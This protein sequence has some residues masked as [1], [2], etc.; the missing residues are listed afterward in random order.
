MGLL[1]P[2]LERQLR[3]AVRARSPA[4]TPRRVWRSYRPRL[5]FVTAGAL[6]A[7][8]VAVALGLSGES[9]SSAAAAALERLAQASQR[10]L[11][12]SRL[13]GGQYWYVRSIQADTIGGPLFLRR[14]GQGPQ[15][16][17]AGLVQR[18]QLV[19][20]W[21][22]PSAVRLRDVP[23][24]GSVFLG[25]AR[26]TALWRANGSPQE[27][28]AA[29][30]QTEVGTTGFNSP[31]GTLTYAQV[32]ALPTNP[33]AML[34]RI[35]AAA[36]AF[37]DQQRRSGRA[38][39]AAEPLPWLE[40]QFAGEILQNLPLASGARAAVYRALELVSGVRYLPHMRDPLGRPGVGLLTRG[41]ARFREASSA[42]AGTNA[43]SAELIFDPVTGAVLAQER[44]L[45][46]PLPPVGLSSGY[47]MSYT[48]YVLSGTVD[49]IHERFAAG[50]E[51]G[52][53]APAPAASPT[54]SGLTPPLTQIINAP[55]PP[56]LGSR[57]AVLRR[58][59]GIQ[60]APP[61]GIRSGLAPEL[62]TAIA[63]SLRQLR[64]TQSGTHDYLVVG[65][66]TAPPVPPRTCFPT[67]SRSKYLQ[68][69]D[70]RNT[71][72]KATSEPIL[73][74]FEVY[75]PLN[76]PCV[77]VAGLESIAFETGY[78]SEAVH[79]PPATVTGIVPDGV[80]QIEAFY[81]DGKHVTASV[82]DNLVTYQ[83]ALPATLATPTRVLWIDAQ[84]HTVRDLNTP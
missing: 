29:H 18:R 1:M 2:E 21:T 79:R 51:G 61:P 84:S 10:G 4:P 59:P 7:V 60:D 63:G 31:L 72:R 30:D 13:G 15:I 27:Q 77:S 22:S 78:T 75:G 26:A 23:A 47:P 5:L 42:F 37:T 73:C 38:F 35:A 16:P 76:W 82:H 56:A 57:F 55:I 74:V 70:S 81:P 69:V 66:R 44:L 33:H 46:K 71:L 25:S 9:S 41:A 67:L 36:T 3:A 45:E 39:L 11:A 65:Y 34:A 53:P 12:A 80:R 6:V 43:V 17:V 28:P 50:P 32:L 64:T 8:V 83:V 20:T 49:S 62:S 24:G 54:C 48:V 52:Q 68:L 40:L 19:E 58:A 14:G